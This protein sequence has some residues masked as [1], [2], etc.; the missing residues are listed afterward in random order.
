VVLLA[1]LHLPMTEAENRFKHD[2]SKH[3]MP[4]FWDISGFLLNA[5]AMG[6]MDAKS[7]GMRLRMNNLFAGADFCSFGLSA[8]D[9]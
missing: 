4:S 7:K 9:E 8:P 2:C 5:Y 6:Q 3:G 1:A